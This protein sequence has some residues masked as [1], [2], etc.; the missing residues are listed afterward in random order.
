[1][2]MR[3][4]RYGLLQRQRRLRLKQ[5]ANARYKRRHPSHRMK[6]GHN[7]VMNPVYDMRNQVCLKCGKDR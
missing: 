7:F 4:K 3:A 2:D 5:R 6:Y 1:M